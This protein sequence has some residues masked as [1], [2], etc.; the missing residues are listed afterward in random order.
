MYVMILNKTII[1]KL[2]ITILFQFYVN[3]KT[4]LDGIFTFCSRNTQAPEALQLIGW[5]T[6]IKTLTTSLICSVYF[7]FHVITFVE[8]TIHNIGTYIGAYLSIWSTDKNSS[9]YKYK[10]A[11]ASWIYFAKIFAR[12]SMRTLI[13]LIIALACILLCDGET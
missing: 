9:S 6:R 7:F 3:I 4:A 13:F 2:I 12:I 10:F 1:N 5:Q 8:Y 11:D